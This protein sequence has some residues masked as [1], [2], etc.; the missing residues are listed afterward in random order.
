MFLREEK[1]ERENMT[2]TV[3]TTSDLWNNIDHII[4]YRQTNQ[5]YDVTEYNHTTA[6]LNYQSNSGFEKPQTP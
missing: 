2:S 6:H 4:M 5:L 3:Y 1:R